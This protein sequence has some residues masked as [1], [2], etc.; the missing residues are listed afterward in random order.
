M[1]AN[2]HHSELAIAQRR[3][4]RA[5]RG[6]KSHGDDSDADD[7]ED[8]L[9]EEKLQKQL[10]TVTDE[11]EIK[12]IKRCVLRSRAVSVLSPHHQGKPVAACTE[13]QGLPG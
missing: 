13:A 9:S 7:H 1:S 4:S 6:R 8:A 2:L 12:R 10:R 3:A 11:K 5:Q